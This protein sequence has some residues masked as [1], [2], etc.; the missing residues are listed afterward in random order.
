M[1]VASLTPAQQRTN[2]LITRMLDDLYW[3]MSYSRWKDDRYW[4]AF[5]DALLREHPQLSNVRFGQ[6]IAL[7]AFAVALRFSALRF[8]H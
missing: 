4:P 3:V 8:A 6:A 5:H 7:L 1:I 2:L